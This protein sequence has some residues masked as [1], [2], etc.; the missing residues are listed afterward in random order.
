MRVFAGHGQIVRAQRAGD[1]VDLAAPAVAAGAVFEFEQREVLH[2]AQAQGARRRQSGH[3]AAQNQ[4]AG[5]VQAGR[6]RHT[7]A[8][9]A[10][11]V[12]AFVIDADKTAFD[13]RCSLATQ[14]RQRGSGEEMAALHAGNFLKQALWLDISSK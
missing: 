11:Q 8:G 12:A 7:A 3:A 5:G 14:Q 4:H 6:R 10:Q 13:L 9:G 1:A 2:A